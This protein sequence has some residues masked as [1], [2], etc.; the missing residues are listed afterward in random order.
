M[1][2]IKDTPLVQSDIANTSNPK[3]DQAIMPLLDRVEQMGWPGLHGFVRDIYGSYKNDVWVAGF[4]DIGSASWGGVR[5]LDALEA[6]GLSAD[7]ADLYFCIGPMG[8]SATRRSIGDVV[9]QPVLIV[10]EGGRGQVG[11]PV[12]AGLSGADVQD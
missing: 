4:P 1:K 5:G 7:A 3:S 11:N 12:C 10:D 6:R 9:A 8:Q 2:D